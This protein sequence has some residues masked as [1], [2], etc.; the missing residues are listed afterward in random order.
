MVRP[1]AKAMAV[2]AAG[3]GSTELN[4]LNNKSRHDLNSNQTEVMLHKIE[5]KI[6]AD[7]CAIPNQESMKDHKCAKTMYAGKPGACAMPPRKETNANSAES[8]NSV[9]EF[10]VTR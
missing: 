10:L 7:K 3:N 4:I 2:I 8:A 1:D 5:K 6:N 9:V